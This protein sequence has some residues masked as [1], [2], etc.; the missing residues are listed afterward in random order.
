MGM[1]ARWRKR[2]CQI[3]R[4]S[5]YAGAA[6]GPGIHNHENSRPVTAT[7]AISTGVT[8]NSGLATNKSAVADLASCLPNS[9]TPEFGRAPE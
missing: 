1:K 9:G 3:A 4:H 6:R 2:F 5:G 8:M 7:N